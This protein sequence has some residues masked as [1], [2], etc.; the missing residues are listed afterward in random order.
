M[1]CYFQ[2]RKLILFQISKYL[3]KKL[4][5]KTSF[6]NVVWGRVDT[7]D[8]FD[9][10]MCSSIFHIQY[11]QNWMMAF[12]GE[13]LLQF[14]LKFLWDLHMLGIRNICVD[15]VICCSSRMAFLYYINRNYIWGLITHRLFSFCNL[16]FGI[17]NLYLFIKPCSS[18][19]N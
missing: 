19:W 8:K 3:I 1:F 13:G 10:F 4:Y 5:F 7:W 9:I 15:W 17:E 16:L 6:A 12:T 14:E 11:D 2:A 18:K